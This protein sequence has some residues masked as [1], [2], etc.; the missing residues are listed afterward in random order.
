MGGE[1]E[2]I[3]CSVIQ[4]PSFQPAIACMWQHDYLLTLIMN[5][6]RRWTWTPLRDHTPFCVMSA[7]KAR[8]VEW[9]NTGQTIGGTLGRQ[10]PKSS[11]NEF[12]YPH[13]GQRSLQL[14]GRNRAVSHKTS[15]Y[16]IHTPTAPSPHPTPP[17]SP[18]ADMISFCLSGRTLRPF[19]VACWS[20]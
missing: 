5:N 20:K 19:G 14:Q 8:S 10:F 4:V 2:I 13:P 18:V 6:C 7:Q 9:W 3:S 1:K 15:H 11:S 17:S 16:F 12:R